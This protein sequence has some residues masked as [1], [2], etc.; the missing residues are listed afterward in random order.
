MAWTYDADPTTNPRDAVRLLLGDTDPDDPQLSDAEL[1]YLL[2]QQHR[3]LAAAAA[4]AE[5]LAARYAREVDL[6]IGDTREQAS[7]R[8]QHY[9]ALAA[10]L[11]RRLALV[12]RPLAPGL[13]A[14]R[15]ARR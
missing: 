6:Q 12:A 15:E 1:D 10:Q 4:G 5:L 7:Q 3:P 9:R 13:C 11:R 14:T 8:W 2:A